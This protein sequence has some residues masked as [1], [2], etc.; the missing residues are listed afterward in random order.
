MR[1]RRLLCLSVWLTVLVILGRPVPAA[2]WMEA[3]QTGAGMGAHRDRPARAPGAQTFHIFQ[4]LWRGETAVEDGFRSYLTER[5]IPFRLTVADLDRDP[6]RAPGI[7][8]RIKAERPDL[9][10]TWGT[11][12]TL[13]IVGGHDVRDPTRHVT[14]IPAVFTLVA[15]P[16][17]AGLIRSDTVPGGN[18]TGVRF[19][20]PIEAQLATIRAYRP[21]SRL[22]VIYNPVETNS[23]LNVQELRDA[24]PGFGYT[25]IEQPAPLDADGRPIGSSVP[26]LVAEARAAGADFLYIGPDSFT[27]VHADTLTGQAIAQSL[28]TFAA[29]ELPL[30]RARA[31]M[32]LVGQYE[33]IGRLAALQAERILVEKRP[34]GTLPVASLERFSLILKMDVVRDLQLYPPMRMLT[35]AQAVDPAGA[36]GTSFP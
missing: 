11:S 35:I 10:Y 21:F 20:A 23:R 1:M 7:V 3:P 22:A 16:L 19:L 32:G 28:P 6:T 30:R 4:V 14:D 34:P 29:T 13:N 12:T 31:M 2:A 18:L 26:H 9:V 5:R 36:T 17:A 15:Y 27:A 24:A 33:T 8:A 25:L